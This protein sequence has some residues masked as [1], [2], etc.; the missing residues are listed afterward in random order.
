MRGCSKLSVNISINKPKQNK[1]NGRLKLRQEDNIKL[2]LKETLCNVKWIKL[3]SD[4]ATSNV[5]G[6]INITSLQC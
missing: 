5:T 6:K 2:I 1:P 4:N 3:A